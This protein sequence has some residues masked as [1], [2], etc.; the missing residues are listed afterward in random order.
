MLNS[1]DSVLSECCAR[2]IFYLRKLYPSGPKGSLTVDM[3]YQNRERHSGGRLLCTWREFTRGV[4]Y[5]GLTA[6]SHFL[7]VLLVCDLN[8][9]L[10]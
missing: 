10:R 6:V 3:L 5:R 7:H 2:C 9:P 4:P 8:R 1:V